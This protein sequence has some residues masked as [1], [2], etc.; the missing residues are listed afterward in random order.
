MSRA[1]GPVSPLVAKV[2]FAGVFGFVGY[3]ARMRWMSASFSEG[4][5][6][7][8]H[9]VRSGVLAMLGGTKM[10][11]SLAL[12]PARRVAPFTRFARSAALGV[13]V[14]KVLSVTGRNAQVA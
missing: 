14:M 13:L 1:V 7:C 3:A 12:L 11:P 5:S 9:A 10:A 4:N 6:R 8:S 2:R